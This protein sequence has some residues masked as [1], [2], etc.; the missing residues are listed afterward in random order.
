VGGGGVGEEVDGR[1]E[2]VRVVGVRVVGESVGE[3]E[4]VGE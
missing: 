3:S 4:E 1:G 2:G